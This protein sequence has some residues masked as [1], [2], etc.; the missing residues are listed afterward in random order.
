MTTFNMKNS[1]YMSDEPVFSF[2]LKDKWSALTHL[3][4]FAA[5]IVI[6]PV[7]LIHASVNGADRLSLCAYSVFM[8]SMILLYGASFSYHAFNISE[9]ANL[10]L[11]KTDH[12][13]IFILIAGSYTPICLIPLRHTVGPVLLA[14]I[15]GAALSGMLFKFCWVTC[16]KWVSSVIYTVMGWLCI[17][18]LPAM[19]NALSLAAVLW[20]AAGGI[21]YSIGAVFY[22]LK[23]KFITSREF[24]CHEIFHCFVLAGSFCHL[25]VMMHYLCAISLI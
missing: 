6:M 22:A 23:P 10:I 5:A 4:G 21:L 9:R 1:V 13:S 24:G 8:L 12:M 20:L 3:F 18:C 16:P 25:V 7:L 11:K 19:V 14:V 17:F 2:R 15:W